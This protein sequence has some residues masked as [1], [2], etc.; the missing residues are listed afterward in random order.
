MQA[1]N[2]PADKLLFLGVLTIGLFAF[3]LLMGSASADEGVIIGD[4]E[5]EEGVTG[6]LQSS[7]VTLQV[8]NN[9]TE[10]FT[11]GLSIELDA[12]P[13]AS[14]T[15]NVQNVDQESY[16]YELEWQP[17]L[18]EI[19]TFVMSLDHTVDGD[20][21]QVRYTRDIAIH[22]L[23]TQDTD[24]YTLS[25]N[26]IDYETSGS[27]GEFRLTD[28]QVTIGSQ[29]WRVFDLDSGHD[30]YG[31]D[32][33]VALVSPPLDLTLLESAHLEFDEIV[34]LQD[35]DVG[36][37]ELT[38]N[39]HQDQVP[40]IDNDWK[41]LYS[42][43][44]QNHDTWQTRQVDLTPWV[45]QQVQLQFRFKSDASETNEGWW[46]DGFTLKGAYYRNEIKV[47]LLELAQTVSPD[48]VQT[49]NVRLSNNGILDQTLGNI[50]LEASIFRGEHYLVYYEPISVALDSQENREMNLQLKVPSQPGL[51]SV[52]INARLLGEQRLIDNEIL[53]PL[54]VGQSISNLVPD[55][56]DEQSMHLNGLDYEVTSLIRTEQDLNH[57]SQLAV[58]W[59]QD[60]L[61]DPVA[62]L[63]SENI[64]YPLTTQSYPVNHIDQLTVQ[65]NYEIELPRSKTRMDDFE[66]IILWDKEPI[67]TGTQLV[68]VGESGPEIR[69][70]EI[71]LEIEPGESRKFTFEVFNHGLAVDEMFIG[72]E[73]LDKAWNYE[74]S[75][76]WVKAEPQTGYP[77]SLTLTAPEN[78]ESLLTLSE[79]ELILNSKTGFLRD[80]RT[81]SLS[82][83]G[84]DLELTQWSGDRD[85]LLT[86]QELILTGLLTNLRSIATMISLDLMVTDNN[87]THILETL[88]IARLTKGQSYQLLFNYKADLSGQVQFQLN[89]RSAQTTQETLSTTF[90]VQVVEDPSAS[91]SLPTEKESPM[92][93]EALL[94]TGISL[95]SILAVFGTGM[96]YE[97]LRYTFFK[98]LL[99]LTT[100]LYSR[101][102]HEEMLENDTRDNLV[103]FIYN[104]PGS[105]YSTIM[106][107]LHLSNGM[108]AYHLAILEREQYIVSRQEGIY[109]R[110]YPMDRVPGKGKGLLAS[111]VDTKMKLSIVK[112]VAGNPG[113]TQSDVAKQMGQS[114]QRI[115]YNVNKLVEDRVLNSKREGRTTL[116]Y[117]NPIFNNVIENS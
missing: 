78:E 32:M 117:L 88:N 84:P 35:K 46:I 70:S 67:L 29:A 91:A 90:I 62:F 76:T 26:A 43:P 47:E 1:E 7:A 109:R 64:L 44:S 39:I 68:A 105:N 27:D 101:I 6:Q 18:P 11:L 63:S 31:N 74:L 3:V 54:V 94:V 25:W 83:P 80:E 96:K 69:T 93:E 79:L 56:P 73:G 24:L 15:F 72:V 106:R 100:P 58:V 103:Q 112:V 108:F 22:D 51:Y 4:I 37:V 66:L 14:D 92:Y 55:Q 57:N 23:V 9:Q 30:E 53:A 110:F 111:R 48:T 17:A 52:A 40:E 77:V 33:D 28:E 21:L 107:E 98:G 86:G 97:G 38:T 19:Y 114:R 41:T 8:L 20:D 65:Y 45:G 81:L 102:K 87:G 60:E 36:S 89:L 13:I 104:N 61:N 116:L 2:G 85:S 59:Q 12:K 115:N 99:P 49:L 50:S 10:Q 75:R 16:R 42:T 82:I 5:T 34:Q 95:V 71:E 113:I